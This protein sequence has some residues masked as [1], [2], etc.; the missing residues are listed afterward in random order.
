MH[1]IR[2]VSG[3][4]SSRYS[5]RCL[6]FCDL[7]SPD[8]YRRALVLRIRALIIK[9]VLFGVIVGVP[10]YAEAITRPLVVVAT[11]LCQCF[12]ELFLALPL[13]VWTSLL[14]SNLHTVRDV[15]DEWKAAAAADRNNHDYAEYN[16]PESSKERLHNE[17]WF[18]SPR[19]N[20][21]A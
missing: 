18:Y 10:D 11:N 9:L 14:I 15:W 3:R 13:N 7:N 21:Q 6:G 4:L 2:I 1:N 8:I 20:Y 5:V 19:S 17:C 12:I 16:K